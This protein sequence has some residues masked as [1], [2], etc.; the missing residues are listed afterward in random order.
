MKRIG[1]RLEKL[2]QR[3]A[4][5]PKNCSACGFPQT[6]VRRVIIAE[7]DDPLPTCQICDR[8]LDETGAPLHTPYAHIVL[9]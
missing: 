8:P 7:R 6:G 1:P 5:V 4:L 9:E 2:E 3:Q